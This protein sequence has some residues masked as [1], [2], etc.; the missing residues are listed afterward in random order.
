MDPATDPPTTS[1]AST[2]HPGDSDQNPST[3]MDHDPCVNTTNLDDGLLED[4]PYDPCVNTTLTVTLEEL[5]AGCWEESR[6]SQHPRWNTP[7]SNRLYKQAIRC[8]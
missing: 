2:V 7:D 3:G 5:S 1:Q 8:P 6:V 4:H